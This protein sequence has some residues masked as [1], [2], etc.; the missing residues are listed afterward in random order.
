MG[1]SDS[2]DCK[3]ANGQLE[4]HPTAEVF[5]LMSEDELKALA[6]DIKA[7]GLRQVIILH[8]G[9]ILDGRNRYRACKMAEVEP[10]TM[11]WHG[12]NPTKDV[13]SL[14]LHRRHLNESQ[15]AMVAA[16]I[17]TMKQGQRTD[18]AGKPAKSQTAASPA[19]SQEQAAKLLNVSRDSVQKAKIVTGSGDKELI[20]QVQSG[21]KSVNGAAEEVK[22][23]KSGT[24]YTTVSM[25]APTG[26]SKTGVFKPKPGNVVPVDVK[27]EDFVK[28]QIRAIVDGAV[29]TYIKTKREVLDDVR[30]LVLEID[31]TPLAMLNKVEPLEGVTMPFKLEPTE[32]KILNQALNPACQGAEEQSFAIKFVRELKKRLK[33]IDSLFERIENARIEITPKAKSKIK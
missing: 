27:Y 26:K 9:K 1:F 20:E 10:R 25:D 2:K 7:N 13:I 23:K 4:D 5:P 16:K 12:E 17:A 33:G 30:K 28:S 8:E 3:P 14:N 32:A 6:E 21:K 18:L 15:R 24:G 29:P 22:G 11:K 31:P 19:L